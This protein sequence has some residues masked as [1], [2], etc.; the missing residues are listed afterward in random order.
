MEQSAQQSVTRSLLELFLEVKTAHPRLYPYSFNTAEIMLVP[1]QTVAEH[2]QVKI[3]TFYH[4]THYS[5]VK[6]IL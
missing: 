2:F 5:T 1:V 3:I 6:R 4:I